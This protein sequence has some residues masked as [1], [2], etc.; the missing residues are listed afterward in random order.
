MLPDSSNP[1][2][3]ACFNSGLPNGSKIRA[4]I[5]IKLQK[6]INTLDQCVNIFGYDLGQI[7]IK[8]FEGLRD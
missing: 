5:F 8:I 2:E 4:G 6:M 7:D 1:F 3:A